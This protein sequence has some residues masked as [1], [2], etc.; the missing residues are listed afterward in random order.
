[1]AGLLAGLLGL[2]EHAAGV[3][4]PAGGA[5]P[6]GRSPQRSSRAPF[7]RKDPVAFLAFSVPARERYPAPKMICPRCS[8]ESPSGQKFCG[9]CGAALAFACPSCGT[10][11]PS[12]QKFCG[13]CGTALG[14]TARPGLVVAAGVG[15]VAERR[16]CSVLFCDVVGFTPLSEARDPE[17][18]RELLSEYF[19]VARTVI[20]R[21]GGVVEKFIG[22]AVMAVWGT[23]VAT[24][25]DAERAVRAAL[26]LLAAVA[27]LGAGAGVPGLAVRAGVVTGEVAVT[28]GAV[29]EGMVAGDAVNTA[30][31]VQA[32]ADPGQVLVDAATQ[33]LAGSAVG[34]ADAG[35]HQLKGKAGPV[36]LWRAVRVLAAVG[37]SQRVDG[38]EAP[39][40]G[41]DAELR[42]I[43]ELF[44]AAA[45][46]RVPRLVLVSGPAG[47]GKSR[48]GW[49]FFKYID[50]LAQ[51]VWWHRG[52]CLSYGEGVAFWALAQIVRQRLGIAEEDPAEAAAAKLAV[53]LDRYVPDPGDRAYVGARLGR[54]LGVGVA[55]DDGAALSREELFA[56]WRLFF[57]RLAAQQPVV[58]LVEDAQYADAGL[59]DFLDHLVDWVRDLPVYVLV[60]A[61][62]QP[63]LVRPG[64]GAGRN[65]SMLTLDP[66][67][68]GSMDQLV[69]ALVPG[70]PAAARAKITSQAQGIPL[71]AVETVRSLVDRDIVRPV[72]GAYRLVGDV[73]EL[74]V[75]DS[76]HALLAARL[77]ALDPDVRRLV[78]DA[79]V[80]GSTFPAEA[81]IAVAGQDETVVRAGLAELVRREVFSI[82]ADRLSPERG[83]Y[84]FAQDM[85]R[86]VAYGTLSRRDRKARHLT[87]AAHLRAAFAGDG[88]EVADVIARHYLDA[89]DAVP[90]DGDA[91]QIRGQ[92][93]TALT[94]AADRAVRTGAPARAAA[95]YADAARLTQDG[96]PDG[97]PASAAAV[98]WEHAAE[99]AYTSADYATAVEQAGQAADAYRQGGDTRAAARAQVIAGQALRQW[100]RHAQAREQLTA[101]VA[102]LRDDPD[103]DTVRALGELAALEVFAGSPAAEALSAEA[104]ALGQDLAVDEATL[105]GLFTTRGICH[106]MAGR[107]PEAAAYFQAAA[108]LAGQAGD[109][110]RLGRALGNLSDA[111]T[112][113]DPAAG[114]EAARAAATQ[115]R[116]VGDRGRLAFAVTNLAQALLMTGDWE[117]AD[118]EL[119]QAADADGLAS[120][121]HLSCNRA[122]VAALRGDTPTAQAILAGLGDLRASED[123]QDQANIAV[124]EAFTAAALGQPAAALRH[125]RTALDHAAAIGISHEVLR[126]AW[127]LA[128]RAAHDLTDTA[129]ETGLLALLDGYRPGQL[130]PMQ[131]AE[132]DLARA[133]LAAAAG[134]PDA[135]LAFAAAIAGLRQHSTPYHVAHGLLDHADCLTAHGQADAAAAA[136]GEA[137]GIAA[138]LGCQPLADRAD[139]IQPARPAPWPHDDRTG[140]PGQPAP[141]SQAADPTLIMTVTHGPTS[142]Q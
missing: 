7:A 69:D 79:A 46:R 64:F 73:G 90:D 91:G 36:Q 103:T 113:T 21:Y 3:A 18:V 26:D 141:A 66:L 56:G 53:G 35:E 119:A 96:T 59:L 12:G 5:R 80:L 55:G 49:E 110:I 48:L 43:R 88:E 6:A 60:F 132:R 125:A 14:V 135:V 138:R 77:D 23:P 137:A 1:M 104:L 117:A 68:T 17:A 130:A 107:N 11:S 57:E 139:A 45:G 100:G 47:V 62:A 52:R 10:A 122:W 42:T 71:F 82:S 58:L 29:G 129:T 16:V 131:R 87:V 65:R 8:A 86:Q 84:G 51:D 134:D 67:D 25:G 126:W 81:L 9:E 136:G 76:L 101:A 94:R 72:E 140:P 34:F 33:R 39:L 128:A 78:A 102:V 31:R 50:G 22:D 112:G 32:V 2:G 75:P 63:G 83:S 98:L 121:E 109:P 15:P 133:R 74:A 85:L 4:V 108:R 114:A 142:R 93:I 38:L 20:G 116:Q 118:A 95:S 54:L 41:R 61:R 27:Q 19:G 123:P 127:P 97:Q 106:G 120:I 115:L 37:G 124:A 92:A 105:A 99:A 89:L 24:E 40:T 30:S 13:E 28:L 70:M 111:V 44:H